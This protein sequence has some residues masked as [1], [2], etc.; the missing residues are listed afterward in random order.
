MHLFEYNSFKL[1]KKITEV[2]DQLQ[3]IDN[4][5]IDT[6]LQNLVAFNHTYLIIT[7]N[8]YEKLEKSYFYNDALMEKIDVNFGNYYFRALDNYL[9]KNHCPKAWKIL[10]DSCIEDNK[11]QF[12]Y[13]ALGVNAHVNNDLPQTLADVMQG[14]RFRHDFLL[15]NDIIKHSLHEVV[16]SLREKNLLI[17]ATKNVFEKLYAY[18]LNNLISKWRNEAWSSYLKLTEKKINIQTIESQA[19]KKAE[20]LVGI[21]S[22]L[23]I[24]KILRA[25]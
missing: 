16:R 20:I 22:L 6:K 5:L 11:F 4:E 9:N 1:T 21:N 13:M 3:I 19:K 7:R 14:S 25:R 10:F 24:P 18:Y 2:I 17:N 23:D 15:I 8:V 12:I